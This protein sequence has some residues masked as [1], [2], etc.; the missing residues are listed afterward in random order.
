[1]LLKGSTKL[2]KQVLMFNRFS[3]LTEI[4]TAFKLQQLPCVSLLFLYFVGVP[5]DIPT[6]GERDVPQSNMGLS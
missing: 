1:M 2:R 5:L 3:K 4:W 6:V